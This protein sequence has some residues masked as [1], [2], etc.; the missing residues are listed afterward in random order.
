[1][2][3]RKRKGQRMLQKIKADKCDEGEGKRETEKEVFGW[4]DEQ[5]V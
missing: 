5:D 1:M 4:R 2:N 3:K